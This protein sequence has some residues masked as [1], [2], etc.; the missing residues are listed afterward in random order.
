MFFPKIFFLVNIVVKIK[1]WN[2]IFKGRNGCKKTG[3]NVS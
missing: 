3:K 2:N 1:R